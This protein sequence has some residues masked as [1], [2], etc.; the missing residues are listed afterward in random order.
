MIND[1]SN[2]NE[3]SDKSVNNKKTI[4]SNSNVYRVHT[5]SVKVMRTQSLC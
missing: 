5:M 4:S 1:N 2:S 3:D